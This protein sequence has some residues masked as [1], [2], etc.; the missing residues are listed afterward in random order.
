[1]NDHLKR[2]SMRSH[3]R[4]IKEMDIIL[5]RFSDHCLMELSE[6]ELDIYERLLS[7]NDHDLY[8]WVI[9][10]RADVTEF[11]GIIAKISAFTQKNH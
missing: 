11:N 2:L 4:G 1:M 8:Q 10:G 9:K 7:E 3:R 6:S 5:G